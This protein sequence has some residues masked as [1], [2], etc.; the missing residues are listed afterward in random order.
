M[1]YICLIMSV[2][3]EL[4]KYKLI[5]KYIHHAYCIVICCRHLAGF[6]YLFV[7]LFAI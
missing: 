4:M 1:L 6:M 3:H 7:C 5:N 2:L